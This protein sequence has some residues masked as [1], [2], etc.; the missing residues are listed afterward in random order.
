MKKL[1]EKIFNDLNQ[2]VELENLQ[3]LNP[4]SGLKKD[5]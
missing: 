5:N 4:G 2:A 3:R 1:M